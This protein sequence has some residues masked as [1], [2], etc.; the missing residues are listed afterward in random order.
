MNCADAAGL[1][2]LWATAIESGTATPATFIDSGETLT[3]ETLTQVALV[4]R[5]AAIAER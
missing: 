5:Q 2:E 3:A 1:L 4:L